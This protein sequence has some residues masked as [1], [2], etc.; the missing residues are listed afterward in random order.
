[1]INIKLNEGLQGRKRDAMGDKSDYDRLYEQYLK[2]RRMYLADDSKKALKE[3]LT[4]LKFRLE[5]YGNGSIVD[6]QS[7]D[8]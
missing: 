5:A 2:E 4:D 8:E 3:S 6:F 7:K 1:M